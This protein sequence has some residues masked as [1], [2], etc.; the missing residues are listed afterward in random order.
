MTVLSLCLGVPCAAVPAPPASNPSVHPARTSTDAP[1]V[2]P[3]TN[4][5]ARRAAS[6]LRRLF[7]GARI[8]DDEKTNTL[9]V[10]AAAETVAAMRAVL[11]GIDVKNPLAP[12]TEAI[13]LQRSDPASLAAKLRTAYRAARIEI[14]PRR[15]LMV[16]AT[17]QELAQ[18]RELV[19]AID[20]PP[21]P[22][23]IASAQPLQTE[24]VR[25]TQARAPDVAREISG[26]F[27]AV[28]ARVAGGS[29]IL[30]GSPDDV[31]KAKALVAVIDQ[32]PAGTRFTQV[33]RIHYLDAASV[34]DLVRRSFPAA[35]VEVDKEL[36]AISVVATSAE[37]RRIGD[38][39]AQL[40]VG[41]VAQV[42][43]GAPLVQPGESATLAGG[44]IEVYTLRAAL[45]GLNGAP[46]TSAADIAQTLAAALGQ[47]APDLHVTVAANAAQL[48]LTG[49]ALSL[50][51][52]KDLIAQLDVSQ[53]LVVLDTEILEVDASAAKNLGLS[54]TQ[55]VLSTTYTETNPPVDASSGIAPPLQRLQALGRS[56]L[57]FGVTLNLLIQRGQARVLADPRITTVSG[58]TASIRAG[59]TIGILTT[60]GG[61]T[62]TVATTQLQTFQ[63]GVT[64]DI[65]PVVN[66]ENYISV[67]LH[68]TVN[69]LTGIVNGVPQIAT[70]DTQ[71]T[72]A[73]QE[74]QT[75]IIGGLIQESVNRTE[76]RV[77]LLGDLPLLGRAFRNQSLNSSRNELVITVT[78]HIVTPGE[79][80]RFSGPPLPAIPS[81]QPLPTLPPGAALPP[82]RPSQA[83]PAPPPSAS[84]P[85]ASPSPR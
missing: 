8:V 16:T 36:N 83:R 18:I 70:R 6:L 1:Q 13:P 22:A 34:G 51:L 47:L 69:S 15:T 21:T 77:P 31:A 20:A 75:L 72:V 66:A 43:G 38:A 55:P 33:Y 59:D 57:T 53:K 54:L 48:I 7:P 74:D 73:L 9:V 37:H 52:A 67:A 63:T 3:V 85:S 46:S 28:R 12:V 17:P 64:L 58:R 79:N 10:I 30:T 4:I 27:R 5:P 42:S 81:P 56:P 60:A 39:L 19:A 2:L 78:P 11:A 71:T 49:S 68:P 84:P 23:P 76:S 14:A 29:V 32:P 41:G 45:P 80:V 65:T 62:G 24:A 82:L 35:V 44:Q 40:D 50:K 26:A 61:G 25:V